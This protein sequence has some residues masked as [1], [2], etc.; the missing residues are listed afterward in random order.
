MEAQP[1]PALIQKPQL[2]IQ[3]ERKRF[4]GTVYTGR[5]QLVD[6][7]DEASSCS[8]FQCEFQRHRVGKAAL[9]ISP[10]ILA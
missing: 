5:W 8:E 7:G 9:G 1:L 4:R 2:G 10:Q 3:N 6:S